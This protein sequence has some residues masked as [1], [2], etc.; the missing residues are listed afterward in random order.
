M[1]EEIRVNSEYFMTI[2]WLPIKKK[3]MQAFFSF[4]ETEKPA[5]WYGLMRSVLMMCCIAG[6]TMIYR[7]IDKC[8]QKTIVRSRFI[9]QF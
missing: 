6:I 4:I 9:K 8:Q 2:N 5:E 7:S 1:K 3:D